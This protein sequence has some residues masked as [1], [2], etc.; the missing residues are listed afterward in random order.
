MLAMGFVFLLVLL[1]L[2]PLPISVHAEGLG[3]FFD[4]A[5]TARLRHQRKNTHGC[6]LIWRGRTGALRRARIGLPPY[7]RNKA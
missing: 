7:A 2:P 5:A 6:I 3:N 1:L 4:L